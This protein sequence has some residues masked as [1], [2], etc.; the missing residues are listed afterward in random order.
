MPVI[1]TVISDVTFWIGLGSVILFAYSRFNVSLPDTDEL[2]PPL[3]PRTFTTNFRFQLAALVYVG[4]YVFVYFF[5]LVAGSF[6][7]LQEPLIKLFGTVTDASSSIG[8]PAGTALIATSILPSTPG[9]KRF[10][11][12]LRGKLQAFASI[13]AKAW[14]IGQEMMEALGAFPKDA[15][16]PDATLVDVQNALASH[17]KVFGDLNDLWDRL[18]QVE[19][20]VP[21]RRYVKF[22]G[23]YKKLADKLREAF[24]IEPGHLATIETAR[25]VESRLRTILSRAAR[26]T[27]CAMLN[28]ELSENA[29]RS[30]LNEKGIHVAGGVFNFGPA[31]LFIA[32]CMVAVVTVVGVFASVNIFAVFTGA[33]STEIL[34]QHLG[35]FFSWGILADVTYTLPLILAAGVEMYLLDQRAQNTNIAGIDRAA[36]AL[37]NFLGAAGLAFVSMLAW[38]YVRMRL[39]PNLDPLRGTSA[40]GSVDP[41]RIL[42]WVLPAATVSTIFLLRAAQPAVGGWTTALTDGFFH[43]VGA[44]AA[45]YVSLQLFALSG[46]TFRDLPDGLMTYVSLITPGLIGFSI[47][48]IICYTTRRQVHSVMPV[49]FRFVEQH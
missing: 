22:F 2:S 19:Q 23:D 15:L 48:G 11:A 14:I 12:W 20:F 43:G 5:L 28:A 34:K 47:G 10:D 38:S 46:Y 33:D 41:L 44:A 18:A 32:V 16:V 39:F 45:S 30:R 6:P 37:L 4:I 31:Q 29:V 35:K 49:R 8:T 27:G 40:A 26:F 36:G 13:P 7:G 21:G 3:S 24:S 17:K 9:F 25:Y 42:P 1:G